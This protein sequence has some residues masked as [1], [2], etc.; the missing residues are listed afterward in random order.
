MDNIPT[1]EDLAKLIQDIQV[2]S[3]GIDKKG[4]YDSDKSPSFHDWMANG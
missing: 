2:E 3:V 4:H 1:A